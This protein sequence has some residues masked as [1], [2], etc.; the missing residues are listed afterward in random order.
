MVRRRKVF[1][2]KSEDKE[3][4]IEEKENERNNEESNSLFKDAIA[5]SDHNNAKEGL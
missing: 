4:T 1:S 2:E 3:E 5:F